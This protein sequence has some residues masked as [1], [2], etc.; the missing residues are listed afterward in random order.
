MSLA[1]TFPNAIV[2]NDMVYFISL[3]A[4]E[5]IPN[6]SVIDLE[7]SE[8]MSAPKSAI[9]K[10]L[11]KIVILDVGQVNMEQHKLSINFMNKISNV[12][13][14]DKARLV[15]CSSFCKNKNELFREFRDHWLNE[16]PRILKNTTVRFQ[17]D[18]QT[19]MEMN[20]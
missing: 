18:G 7:C 13:F 9:E 12:P 1:Q 8:R 3:E 17:K 14:E 5:N 10:N 16:K 20:I 6:D 2:S 15:F 11:D 19:V 4:F